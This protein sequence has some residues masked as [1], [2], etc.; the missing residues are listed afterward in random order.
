MKKKL[1]PLEF[2]LYGYDG[3][4]KNPKGVLFNGETLVPYYPGLSALGA[5]AEGQIGPGIFSA[6]A[7]Y[8]D[9]RE[10]RDGSNPLVENS[11]FK[12]L[13]GYRL[14]IDAHL[15][16]GAQWYREIMM[17]YAAYR[18]SVGNNPYSR[19][20]NQDTFTL[21]LTYKAKQ[22][23]LWITLFSYIRPQDKDSF[24][25][26]DISKRLDNHFSIT[27]GV[28]LFTG[29]EHYEDREFGMQR[30]DDNLFLRLRYNF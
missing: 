12:Y 7:G 19:K 26:L 10:D 23:T 28:N 5:S 22:E 15:S 2:V 24:T 8:Y 27:A 29:T 30:H 4:Y 14:D 25:R 1:G 18:A 13:V 21:R 16:A 9:S 17:D 11:T 20:K 6:E 3:F